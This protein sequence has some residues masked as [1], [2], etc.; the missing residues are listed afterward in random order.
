MFF[1]RKMHSTSEF[2]MTVLSMYVCVFLCLCVCVCVF[3]C[4]SWYTCVLDR[5][6]LRQLGKLDGQGWE[7]RI[8]VAPA[9][10]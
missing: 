8:E 7:A 6:Q 1:A 10:P 4:V 2:A 5:G 3:N 9:S